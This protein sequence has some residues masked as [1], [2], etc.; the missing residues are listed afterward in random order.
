VWSDVRKLCADPFPQPAG[1]TL[2]GL[3]TP[4]APAARWG[5]ATMMTLDRVSRGRWH[6]RFATL[7]VCSALVGVVTAACDSVPDP[8]ACLDV[9]DG[10]CPDDNGAAVCQDVTCNAVYGCVNGKWVFEEAC[11]M[12]ASDAA[13]DSS[14]DSIADSGSDTM[15]STVDTSID[16][17]AG[18]NG[19][20]GCVDL[21]LPDCSLGTALACAAAVDCCGCEDIWICQGGGWVPWGG[22]TDAGLVPSGP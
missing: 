11:P 17:P 2:A 12:R 7:L 16:V 22:C 20:Q 15:A 19:G 13:A 5:D 9:P 8:A 21:E 14:G 18:A 10:G 6:L 1:P 3:S 4:R